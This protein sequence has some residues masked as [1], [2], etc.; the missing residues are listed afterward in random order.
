LERAT[1]VELIIDGYFFT[2]DE[3]NPLRRLVV[4]LGEGVSTVDSQ[5]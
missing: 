4:G 2:V 5:V 1:G 3:G